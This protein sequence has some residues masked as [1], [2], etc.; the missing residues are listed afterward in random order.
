MPSNVSSPS[1]ARGRHKVEAG[2][3]VDEE[4]GDLEWDWAKL[5]PDGLFSTDPG[6]LTVEF[7]L[8]SKEVHQVLKQMPTMA[9]VCMLSVTKLWMPGMMDGLIKVWQ[10]ALTQV[11]LILNAQL[12]IS[13]SSSDAMSRHCS[14]VPLGN[15][16]GTL[17]CWLLPSHSPSLALVF[18]AFICSLTYSH[19]PA[20]II[21]S[22]CPIIINLLTTMPL[23]QSSSHGWSYVS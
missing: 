13:W 12:P 16:M 11:C 15:G 22:S 2:V 6:L 7:T 1:S 21:T 8:L 10:T 4:E 17:T 3:G 20:Y 9:D 5:L 18:A 23:Q 14:G 19:P